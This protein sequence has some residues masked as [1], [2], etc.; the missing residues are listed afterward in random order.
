MRL[1]IKCSHFSESNAKIDKCHKSYILQLQ[2]NLKSNIQLFWAFTKS[3]RQ[4]NSYPT[5]FTY[6]GQVGN[7][8]NEICNLFANFFES[9]YTDRSSNRTIT[10]RNVDHINNQIVISPND[11]FETINSIDSNKN[12]GPDGIPNYFLKQTAPYISIPLAIIFNKS[13]QLSVYPKEF[14]SSFLTP[15]FKKGDESVVNNY[16]PIC[17]SNTMSTIFEK[18]MNKI[19]HLSVGDQISTK[20]HGFTKGKSTNSH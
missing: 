5:Q 13:L 8:S 4:T 2:N 1:T 16:R 7:A 6:N 9:T 14:K 12:G 17:M 18:L 19:L 10:D 15:I 11:V 3:K 20:Q